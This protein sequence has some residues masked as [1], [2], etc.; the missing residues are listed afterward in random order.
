MKITAKQLK[1]LI[2]EQIEEQGKP[3][4]ISGQDITNI[5]DDKLRAMLAFTLPQ[6][7]KDEIHQELKRR[8]DKNFSQRQGMQQA[9]EAER[10]SA[11]QGKKALEKKASGHATKLQK[12]FS[13]PTKPGESS[14]VLQDIAA[15]GINSTYLNSYIR[16]TLGAEIWDKKNNAWQPALMDAAGDITI[17]QGPLK[18]QNLETVL[19][20]VTNKQLTALLP[21]AVGRGVEKVRSALPKWLGGLEEIVKEEVAN[22][23]RNK[24]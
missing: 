8:D 23:L 18:G 12:L 17:A 22:L 2:L 5:D 20:H 15:N 4:M 21:G 6:R 1:Q 14:P 9:A 13:Q 19:S 24:R 16:G 7:D 3:Y 11:R 10:Q